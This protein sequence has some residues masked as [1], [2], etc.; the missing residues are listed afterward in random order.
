MDAYKEETDS[1]NKA[2][3][4]AIVSGLPLY[5]RRFAGEYLVIRNKSPRTV[6]GYV[7][8]IRSFFRYLS[9]VHGVPIDEISCGFLDSLTAD[10]LQDYLV[11]MLE[12]EDDLS[13]TPE[14]P[15]KRK[16]GASARARKL[17]SIKALY[18]YLLSRKLIENNVPASL[19]AP[20][21]D[22][23]D[24]VYLDKEEV[25]SVMYGAETGSSLT[26]S[27]DR[28]SKKQRLRDIAILTLLLNTGLRVSELVGIDVTDI[29]WKEKKIKV[30]RKGGKEQGIY[31]NDAVEEALLDYIENERRTDTDDEKALFISRMKQRIT[32][33]SVERLVKK[34]TQNVVTS[35]K[36][37]PHKLRSTF[38]TTL[39][40]DTESG[41]GG[42]IYIVADA[43]GH[44]SLE[45]V[46]KYTNI[47]DDRRRKAG[48]SIRY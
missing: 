33:R 17:S 20:K 14:K 26:R 7:G 32:V 38:A 45:T 18:N 41:A 3:I 5:V 24:V 31:F 21:P 4:D 27:Q 1:R 43:L 15:K 35:K 19:V 16:N 2:A 12:Y 48:S 11:Y 23:K 22:Q 8:D 25:R 47:S 36:I 37:T 30:R 42:D 29:D 9:D 6:L 10:D 13:G 34:Y 46:K 40:G 44:S 28:Y 39:Y